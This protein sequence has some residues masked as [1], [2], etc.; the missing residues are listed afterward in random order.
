MCV[1]MAAR[2]CAAQ[3]HATH[4]RA[5]HTNGFASHVGAGYL[6]DFPVMQSVQKHHHSGIEVFA[7]SIRP[8]SSSCSQANQA[9]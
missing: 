7:A 2:R 5:S 4:A 3:A 1:E 8:F 6:E 9:Y